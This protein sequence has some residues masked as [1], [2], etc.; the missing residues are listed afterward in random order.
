MKAQELYAKLKS[1][2]IKD[3]IQDV[4]W[5]DR[6]PN[7]HKYLFPEFKQNGGMGLMCDFADEIEKVYT[8]V[9]LSENVLTKLIDD[10]IANAMLFSH[11]PT[12]WDLKH[13]NGNYAAEESL[14]AELKKRNISVYILHCPL[15]NY[16]EYSTCKKLAEK[17]GIKIERPAFL[18]F[19]AMC[20]V[21]G[22][23][24][25]N[26]LD[27]LSERYS[28]AVGHGTSLY[29]YGQENITNERI[30][31]CPGGG[32]MISI[33][34]EML[35]NGIGTL[36]TGVTLINEYSKET[37]EYEKKNKINLLGGTHYSSEKFA[38]MEMCRYFNCVGLPSEFIQDEPNLFDL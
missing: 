12:N 32:N 6:M 38:S 21:I 14:V 35:E 5:A 19:G 25:C 3:G 24:D 27:E 28:Q 34:D 22:T 8:T 11:H 37:H 1:D 9:F 29:L 23:I 15:D 26:T 20:G 2:F 4:C 10:K 7:L 16:G 30:A 18:Y 17:I 31:V 36:I 13:H 33:V